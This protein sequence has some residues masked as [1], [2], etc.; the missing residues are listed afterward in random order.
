MVGNEKGLYLSISDE[1][2]DE[3]L[4]LMFPFTYMVYVAI[5]EELDNPFLQ[6]CLDNNVKTV[7]DSD[8][9]FKSFKSFLADVGP[10]PEDIQ[11][12]H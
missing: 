11:K 9:W 5:R 8:H 1:I 12:A 2:P 10:A 6:N 3:H 4:I 7:Y